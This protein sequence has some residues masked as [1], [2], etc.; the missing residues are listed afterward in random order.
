MSTQKHVSDAKWDIIVQSHAELAERAQ[1]TDEKLDRL[2]D[3]ISEL[4]ATLTGYA[5]D[6]RHASKDMDKVESRVDTLEDEVE[7]LKI[8]GATRETRLKI[9]I[10]I[11]STALASAIA[12]FFK[13][14]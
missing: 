2:T 6:L 13:G 11:V 10:G 12:W 14:V 9:F 3:S 4:T 1:K 7:I 5:S 8:E